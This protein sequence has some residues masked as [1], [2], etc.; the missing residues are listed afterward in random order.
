LSVNSILGKAATL[1]DRL[2]RLCP[3]SL[4]REDFETKLNPRGSSLRPKSEDPSIEEQGHS[5]SPRL[6]LGQRRLESLLL[7]AYAK[8][9]RYEVDSSSLGKISEL[10]ADIGNWAEEMRVRSGED[11]GL[12]VHSSDSA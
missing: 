8:A 2:E 7:L 5:L 4:T 12:I 11:E 3:K 6:F 9:K 10:C 1:V